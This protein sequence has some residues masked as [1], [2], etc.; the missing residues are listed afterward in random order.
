MQKNPS[1]VPLV[2]VI[3]G[4]EGFN[5]LLRNIMATLRSRKCEVIGIDPKDLHD[6]NK[7]NEIISDLK[8]RGG[9]RRYYGVG[10]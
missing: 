1:D 7:L 3:G 5:N 10:L 9:K 2:F 4:S 6:W 8:A